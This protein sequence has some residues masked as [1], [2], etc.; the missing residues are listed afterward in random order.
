MVD[1]RSRPGSDPGPER[2][3]SSLPNEI[4]PR[5][6]CRADGLR[7]TLD[8]PESWSLPLS[9]P[10]VSSS[11][12]FESPDG[13]GP[14]PDLFI[15]PT[16]RS[17]RSQGPRPARALGSAGSGCRTRRKRR[18]RALVR[19]TSGSFPTKGPPSRRQVGPGAREGER[20]V[21]PWGGCGARTYCMWGL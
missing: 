5:V 1:A 21:Q 3:I 2:A 8:H 15:E 13:E 12:H 4:K 14:L 20:R 9:E 6:R 7:P 11:G 18:T 19:R 10:R 17:C 16:S